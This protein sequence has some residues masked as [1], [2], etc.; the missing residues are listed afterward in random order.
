MNKQIK[1]LPVA[2]IV[3]STLI[4]L[5][6][7]AR[8]QGS[9]FMY[10]GQLTGSGAPVNGSFDMSFTLFN[11]NSNVV[12]IAGPITNSATGVTNGLFTTTIDFGSGVFTGSNYWLQVS[13]RTNGNGTFAALSPL[14]PI[15][16]TPYAVYSANAGNAATATTATTATSAVTAGI[17]GSANSVSAA[18]IVGNIQV[19]QLPIGVVINKQNG[20]TLG[21]TFSGN[22]GG[23]TNLPPNA[24]L[25]NS[26][27]TFK[28]IN[29]FT[30]QLIAGIPPISANDTFVVRPA[31]N[32]WLG[33]K[34]GWITSG[35]VI[36]SVNDAL[37][38]NVPLELRGNPTVFTVG[39]TGFGTTG[40]FRFFQ[41][42]P[43]ANCN[44][45]VFDNTGLYS[46]GVTIESVNDANNANETLE[47]RGSPC[48][49]QANVSIG[50]TTNN[51]ERLEVDGTDTT[52]RIRN[53]NDAIGGFAGDTFTSVQLGM[54]NP[55]VSTQGV[56]AAGAK[57]SFFGFNENGVVGS[58]LNNFPASPSYRNV[59]DDGSGDM[60]IAGNL[61][62][63][64]TA[65]TI[66]SGGS[67][68]IRADGNQNFF[69]GVGA[70]NLTLSGGDNTGVGVNALRNNTTGSNNI[71]VGYQSGYNITTGSSNIDIGNLGVATDTNIVRIGT[72]QAATYLAGT[73]YA[74][75]VA[76]TSDRNAKENFATLDSQSVLAKVAALPLMEWN[77][78]DT[79]AMVR[80]VG[81]MAQDF[82]AAFQL[83]GTDDKHISVVDES[84]VALAAI[85]GLNEKLNEKDAEIQ[86]LKQSVAD[87]K[88]MVQSL[89]EK[90]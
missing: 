82:H 8:A 65:D 66:Y 55:S 58:L 36:E 26:N 71:A 23:L 89:A 29:L 87:L 31:T 85:Q 39:N 10:Q 20:V 2:L 78:K 33:I 30:N 62:L 37:S 63:P 19:N 74:N 88:K 24:A 45:G 17:A 43:A 1:H 5:P 86:E 52:I 79:S 4:L 7:T 38:A 13:V 84:G 3:L 15:L 76:L 75:G 16:P 54:Y 60:S 64:A 35:T 68:L 80:H 40:P 12:L 34:A 25:L 46:S 47:F 67:T 27:Q 77:Y 61:T 69:S 14:Q 81:P 21:G 72:T 6:R 18:N 59:L 53:L 22:G 90:K 41:V 57:R 56:M 48:I 50:D 51:S 83:N 70:G 73:V 11:A 44:L 32:I 28:G 9:A 42:H 49:F